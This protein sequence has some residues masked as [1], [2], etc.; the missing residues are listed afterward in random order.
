[1]QATSVIANISGTGVV[2]QPD[3]ELAFIPSNV[4]NHPLSQSLSGIY[5]RQ[6]TSWR[7]RKQEMVALELNE[8]L[9]IYIRAATATIGSRGYVLYRSPAGD[10]KVIKKHLLTAIICSTATK[11]HIKSGTL[12]C[13]PSSNSYRIS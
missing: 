3:R 12:N 4:G 1:M 2:G 10:R 9:R 6:K 7:R 11:L 5:Q 13:E 8:F